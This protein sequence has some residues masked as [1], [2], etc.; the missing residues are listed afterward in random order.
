MAY[1]PRIAENTILRL[2]Y[3]FPVLMVT[4]ARQVGKTTLLQE[5]AL[6]A[7]E[8]ENRPR[9]FVSLASPDV[10]YFAI[11]EPGLFFERYQAPILVDE[12]QYAPD[13]LP[14]I[15]MMVDQSARK[16]DFWL[17]SSQDISLIPTISE[18][19]AGRVGL[20]SL[21]GLS[22]AEIYHVP[23]EPYS[24]AP[25][26][27]L[28]KINHRQTRSSQ[29]IFARI[30]R[31]S[32]PERYKSDHEDPSASWVAYYRSYVGAFL[33]RDLRDIDRA[34]N[35]MDF[36]HVMLLLA[37]RIGQ[38]IIY[39]D[40]AQEARIPIDEIKKYV[41]I[42]ASTQLVI[43]VPPYVHS[44]LKHPKNG[45]LLYFLDTGLAAFLLQLGTLKA[46]EGSPMT[47][48]LFESYVVGEIYKSYLNA[49]K[50]PP[51]SFYG[52]PDCNKRLLL[53]EENGQ[54][55][56]IEIKKTASP[57]KKAV[58]NFPVLESVSQS[59]I[60]IGPGNVICLAPDLMPLDNNNWAVPA[61]LV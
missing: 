6:R 48:V 3:M 34:A 8:E 21:S 46:L 36:Y 15:K 28:A 12:I 14:Y 18:Y 60:E 40:L 26:A 55:S 24:T 50:T 41:S 44:G 57:G 37:K 51:L 29:E 42:M 61:W 38:A 20:V 1:I 2:S 7:N 30:F 54:V 5:L 58:K 31:G 39:K 32:M 59:G 13:L 56:P 10:R 25:A 35:E 33:E 43:L 22:D 16:G 47:G 17:T 27:L 4:G 45:P 9:L 49:G 11:H 52:E 19:L 23:S 53:L